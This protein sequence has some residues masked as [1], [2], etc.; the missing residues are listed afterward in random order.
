MAL[1]GA[2][3]ALDSARHALDSDRHALEREKLKSIDV[4]GCS[5]HV[6]VHPICDVTHRSTGVVVVDKFTGNAPLKRTRL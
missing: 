5:A 4:D 2:R 6:V 1:D 3:H